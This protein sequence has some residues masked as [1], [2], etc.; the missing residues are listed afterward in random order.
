MCVCVCV[1]IYICVCLCVNVDLLLM[2]P[3][4]LLE[5]LEGMSIDIIQQSCLSSAAP[6]EQRETLH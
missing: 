5:V 3:H 1:Y 2:S 6:L 4:V